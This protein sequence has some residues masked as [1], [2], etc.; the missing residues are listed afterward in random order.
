MWKRAKATWSAMPR[1]AKLADLTI[2]AAAITAAVW[3]L[4]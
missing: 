4:L 2:T 3:W 1:W